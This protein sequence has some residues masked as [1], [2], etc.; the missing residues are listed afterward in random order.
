MQKSSIVALVVGLSATACCPTGA[1]RSQFPS[2]D[3]AIG[4]MKATYACTNGVQGN[5]KIDHF[6]PKAGSAAICTSSRST[7]IAFAS[8]W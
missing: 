4:R 3:D 8:T 1:P 2:A 6:S 5:A 7:R